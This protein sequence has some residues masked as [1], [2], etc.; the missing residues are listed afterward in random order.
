MIKRSKTMSKADQAQAKKRIKPK[1]KKLTCYLDGTALCIVGKDFVNIQE[2]E[3]VFLTLSPA[4][5]GKIKN[6][7][8]KQ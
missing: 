8:D 3:C 5:Y 2:S 4:N 7:Q 1:M 6:L